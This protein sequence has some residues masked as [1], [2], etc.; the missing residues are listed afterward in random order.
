M[1]KATLN[2]TKALQK[3]EEIERVKEFV[4]TLFNG[5]KENPNTDNGTITLGF[6]TPDGVR[7]LSALSGQ[8]IK[9]ATRFTI[10]LNI[11]RHWYNNH[12]GENEKDKGQNIPL[13]DTDIK[14]LIDVMAK[15]DKILFTG[16]NKKAHANVFALLKTNNS[17]GTYSLLEVY[18]NSDGELNPKSY[19]NSKKDIGGQVMNLLKNSQPFTSETRTRPIDAEIPETLFKVSNRFSENKDTTKTSKNQISE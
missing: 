15:P 2:K 16:Y 18:S 17:N 14:A 1:H 6:L 9:S 3:N 8:K 5:V 12:Y 4:L 13:T 19:Y 7:Y 10:S 11:L